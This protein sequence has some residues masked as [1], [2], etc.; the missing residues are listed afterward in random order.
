MNAQAVFIQGPNFVCPDEAEQYAIQVTGDCICAL[1]VFS[2]G[3]E[4][5]NN[6]D[7]FY[8]FLSPNIGSG[9]SDPCDWGFNAGDQVGPF[10]ICWGEDGGQLCVRPQNCRGELLKEVCKD[11]IIREDC[12]DCNDGVLNGDEYSVDCGGEC[13]D[14]D[15]EVESLEIA[16][17]D[18]V[19][20]CVGQPYATF[21]ATSGL[22]DYQWS[23]SPGYPAAYISPSGS[24][25]SVE[26]NNPNTYAFFTITVTARDCN[27]N[28]L[29]ASVGML[30]IPCG[31][32]GYQQANTSEE[33]TS[34][35]QYRSLTIKPNPIHPNEMLYLEG[36]DLTFEQS[37]YQL[38]DIS[39][40]IIQSGFVNNYEASFRLNDNYQTGIYF[41]RIWDGNG[42]ATTKKLMIK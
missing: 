37:T 28:L 35:F 6:G 4:N 27:G 33:T 13:G 40:K 42:I 23:V 10:P 16:G 36:L 21:S 24:N 32:W 38:I 30:T 9:S 25:A 12:P 22:F 5:C 20:V 17:A 14:C 31:G 18:P 29:T 19:M 1:N 8:Q 34:A 7:T 41:I 15:C 2:D 3:G 11:I 39:G 26:I